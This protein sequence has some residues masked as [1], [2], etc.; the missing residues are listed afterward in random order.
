M[1]VIEL[2]AVAGAFRYGQLQ[3]ASSSTLLPTVE[4]EEDSE[5]LVAF[6]V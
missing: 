5:N 3:F 2:V 4:I 6:E 1:Y